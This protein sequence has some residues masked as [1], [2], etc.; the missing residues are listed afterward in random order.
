MNPSN[1]FGNAQSGAFQ[2]PNNALKSGIF[3]PVFGAPTTTSQPQTMGFFT[4]GFAQPLSSNMFGQAPAF[5]PS[6]AQTPAFGQTSLGLGSSGFG[7][8]TAPAFGQ[9]TAVNQSLVLGPC[10]GQPPGF[11]QASGFGQQATTFGNQ[12][13]GFGKQQEAAPQFGQPSGSTTTSALFGTSVFGQPPSSTS[14]TSLFG[15]SSNVTQTRAFG[16]NKYS[17]KPSN[18][19]LFKPIVSASPE[20]TNPQTTTMS[21]S[22]FGGGVAQTTTTTT[23]SSGLFSSSNP[24]FS[25]SQPAALHSAS[26]TL[27]S[28]SN[29]APLQFTF[30]QPA[31]PASSSNNTTTT[32]TQPTTPSSFSFTSKTLQ[33]QT[34]PIF[35]GTVFGQTSAFGE[36][37]VKE[38]DDKGSSAE[39]SAETNVFARLGTK[40]KEDTPT[41]IEKPVAEEDVPAEAD[42]PR[43]PPKRPLVRSRGPPAEL[44]GK[45]LSGLRKEGT[46][47]SKREAKKLEWDDRDAGGGNQERQRSATP[48]VVKTVTREI[49]E[50]TE[51]TG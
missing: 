16:T 29:T 46:G 21:S 39:P 36:A 51:E 49:P 30:S 1:P 18:E 17:F 7:G 3:Q 12:S 15:V 9:N 23:S 44:F 33:P 48:P 43:Q 11:S 47:P 28:T 8:G 6:S 22:P 24:G 27:T 38:T 35:S 31:A 37:K 2:A 4:S 10:F 14:T 50:K 41:L 5:G 34:K 25:F 26:Q 45:A 13:S 20:P 40:R 19:A 32:S 42:V